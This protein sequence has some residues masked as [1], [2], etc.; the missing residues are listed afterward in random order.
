MPERRYTYGGELQYREAAAGS[1]SPG[2]ITGPVVVYGDVAT[3][4]ALG[5]ERM[6]PGVWGN[7]VDRQDWT[8]NLMHQ[9]RKLLARTGGGGLTLTD[10]SRALSAELVLPP[11]PDGYETAYLARKGI[12]RGLSAEFDIVAQDHATDGVRN[13]RL[14][15]GDAIGV[16]DRPAYRKSQIEIRRA[17]IETAQIRQVDGR[18]ELLGEIPYNEVGIY[19]M[20][21][22]ERVTIRSGA[23][24]NL[25]AGEIILLAGASYETAIASTIAGSLVLRDTPTALQFKARNLPDTSYSAD[26]LEKMDKGLVRGLSVGWADG[27]N[28]VTLPD[29]TFEVNEADLCEIRSL[30]RST[31]ESANISHRRRRRRWVY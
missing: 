10:S 31:H 20:A 7:D 14:A 16:V 4:V 8:A 19:S 18:D 21:R 28:V 27:A 24:R 23:F 3:A 17:E 25:A 30:T 2:T 11:T 29:G 22:G 26:F 15:A 1:L 9:P 6:L 5:P 13:V 12:V